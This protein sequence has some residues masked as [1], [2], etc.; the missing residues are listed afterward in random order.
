MR[1]A[2]KHSFI[3]DTSG[4]P[5]MEFTAVFMLLILLTGAIVDF[6]IAL[7]QWNSAEKATQIGVRIAV[8]TDPVVEELGTFDCNN[9]SISLGTPCRLGGSSFGTISCTSTA[10]SGTGS[11]SGNTFD[12]TAFNTIVNRMQTVYGRIQPA[13]VIIEY[14]DIGLCFAGRGSPCPAVTVRLTALTIDFVMLNWI[15][16]THTMPDFRATLTGEDLSSA[17]TT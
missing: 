3:R 11:L 12:S 9:G 8:I 2:M 10:C 13:N 17:G 16:G 15:F 14:N 4:G 5:M 6:G 7:W 1:Q